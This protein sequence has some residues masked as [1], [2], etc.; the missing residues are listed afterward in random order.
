MY[1]EPTLNFSSPRWAAAALER[2]CSPPP[3]FFASSAAAAPG[4]SSPTAGPERSGKGLKLALSVCCRRY[5]TP[6]LATPTLRFAP[7]Y[8]RYQCVNVDDP[9]RL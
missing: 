1:V 2:R 3:S 5:I 9:V 4:M 7:T 6:A 8:V